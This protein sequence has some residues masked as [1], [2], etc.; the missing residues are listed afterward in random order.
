MGDGATS[1]AV[2]VLHR[3]TFFFPPL[4]QAYVCIIVVDWDAYSLY[5][6]P[7]GL[8]VSATSREF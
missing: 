1:Q 4:S 6:I 7:V 2:V 3:R 5:L 8:S